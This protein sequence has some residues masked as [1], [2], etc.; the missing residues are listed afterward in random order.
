MTKGNV[1]NWRPVRLSGQRLWLLVALIVS[2]PALHLMAGQSRDS[3][4]TLRLRVPLPLSANAL[5][6]TVLLYSVQARIP[7]GVE[8]V[9][10]GASGTRDVAR[11]APET[12]VVR[13]LDLT[14]LPITDVLGRLTALQ[15]VGP[16]PRYEWSVDGAYSIRPALFRNNRGA[17]LNRVV[18]KFESSTAN[19]MDTL[20]DVLRI[21]DPKQPVK[22][23]TPRRMPDHVRP[24]VERATHISLAQVSVHTILNEIARNHGGMSWLVEYASV[25]GAPAGMKLTFVGFDK[26]TLSAGLPQ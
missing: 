12:Q 17:A 24:F 7:I 14:G 11:P 22:S 26:W 19:L 13:A 21:F 25:T 23:R 10:G 4:G 20:F 5:Q 6:G 16:I 2:G 15:V 18:A 1:V 9:S 3:R 8:V